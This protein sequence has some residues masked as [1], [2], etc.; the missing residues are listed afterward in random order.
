MRVEHDLDV[1]RSLSYRSRASLRRRHETTQ[2]RTLIHNRVLDV[3]RV[4]IDRLVVI[5]R[6]VFGV[7]DSGAE[8]FFDLLRRMLLGEPKQSERLVHILAAN[9]IDH[10]PHLVRRL[11]CRALNGARHSLFLSG[12][13]R[14]AKSRSLAHLTAGVPFAGVPVAA[15]AGAAPG[16]P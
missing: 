16:P 13:T 1:A 3:K 9:L 6:T 15:G 10:Q 14:R 11:T 8:N 12:V 7:G 5:P 4:D 2:R